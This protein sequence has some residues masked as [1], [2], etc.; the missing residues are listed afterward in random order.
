MI[1]K[2]INAFG[3]LPKKERDNLLLYIKA[4]DKSG[5]DPNLA[6][7]NKIEEYTIRKKKKYK[8]IM[9]RVND[10]TSRG[11]RLIDGLE[12]AGI[13]TQ[14]EYFILLNSKD[15]LAAG[16]DKIIDKSKSSKKMLMGVVMF[17]G[18]I[19]AI[20]TALLVFHPQVKDIVVGVTAPIRDAGGTPAPIPEYLLDPH[21]YIMLNIGLWFLIITT[22]IFLKF[23]KATR[24]KDYIKSFPLIEQEIMIDIL[25]SIQTLRAGGG[26]NL[27]NAAE[28]LRKGADD[29]IKRK[30]YEKIVEQARDGKN[31][32]SKVMSTFGVSYNT[33]SAL[34]I[35]EDSS[36]FDAGVNIALEDL[37]GRYD[38][39]IS[40][41]LK[42]A[43]WGG[44]FGMMGIAMKPMVDILM[45][46][47]VGQM[48][49]QI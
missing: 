17:L 14:Q 25:S 49:F 4:I 30:I 23:L 48:N 33:I 5:K 39:N 16:I 7:K 12:K 26:M 44:Q 11:G 40:L 1:R 18:P 19:I 31:D 9:E 37:M 43:F 36:D 27:A 34:K 21:A 6:I 20:A 42:T 2:I 3:K 10:V 15:G 45:L 47:S 32:M 29:S 13:I 41:Y 46:M 28:A 8:K 38:R 35:G 22:V 24:P